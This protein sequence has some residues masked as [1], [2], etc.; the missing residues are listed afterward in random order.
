MKD[1]V[2]MSLRE[3]I[4]DIKPLLLKAIMLIIEILY[5]SGDKRILN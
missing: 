1:L 5:I 2:L 4:I 3:R